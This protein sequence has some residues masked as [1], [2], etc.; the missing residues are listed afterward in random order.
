MS[1]YPEKISEKVR[2][3]QS[4]GELR[5][6]NAVGKG[7]SFVCGTFVTFFLEIENDT[8]E[9]VRATYKTSG[10]GFTIAAAE[11]LCAHVSGK[12]LIE[13]HGLDKGVLQAEIESELDK[14]PNDRAHC[15]RI[16]L[17]AL[18][19]AFADF[20]A[21]QIEEFIGERA[22]ICTCFGISEETI[23]NL[24]QRK[25]L[26]TVEEVTASC[27]AGGGCGSCQPLIQEI[28][29]IIGQENL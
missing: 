26:S 4:A 22:L 20:R 12:K 14:F 18:Q 13:L 1:F 10:C 6:A 25:S 24:I 2:R 11:V 21:A 9:I 5:A 28:L 3:P 27:N 29:D 19:S 23:E 17:D 8:K 7:A 15:L 16:C